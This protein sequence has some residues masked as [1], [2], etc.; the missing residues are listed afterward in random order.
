MQNLVIVEIVYN[1][2]S[3]EIRFLI[4]DSCCILRCR[5]LLTHNIDNTKKGCFQFSLKT[6]L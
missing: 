3:F 4:I 6:T 2:L 1:E 5:T